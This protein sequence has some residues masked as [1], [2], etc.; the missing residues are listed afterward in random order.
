M[1]GGGKHIGE[2]PAPEGLDYKRPST[3]TLGIITINKIFKKKKE[4][5]GTWSKMSQCYKIPICSMENFVSPD[6]FWLIQ[7]HF[8]HLPSLCK[9]LIC[10]D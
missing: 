5:H 10:G 9:F 3:C 7:A 4:L 2:D 1:Q 6:V 8:S